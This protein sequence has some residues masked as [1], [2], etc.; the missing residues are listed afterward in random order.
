MPDQRAQLQQPQG[1]AQ[2]VSPLLQ[3][4]FTATPLQTGLL[5][6]PA[7]QAAQGGFGS[8]EKTPE[9][10]HAEIEWDENA[11]DPVTYEPIKINPQHTWVEEGDGQIYTVLPSGEVKQVLASPK[12][13]TGK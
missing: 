13:R 1:L 9:Q 3:A 5:G 8:Q 7:I 2:Q 12:N 10:R 6:V 11:H 4:L